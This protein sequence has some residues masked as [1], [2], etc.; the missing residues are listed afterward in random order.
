MRE[1]NRARN[2]RKQTNYKEVINQEYINFVSEAYNI[3][4]KAALAAFDALTE[5]P[6]MTV[7]CPIYNGEQHLYRNLYM[8]QKQTLKQIQIIYIDDYS[9]DNSRTILKELADLDKRITLIFNDHN[10]GIFASK[11]KA[12]GYIKANYTSLFDMDD[13]Y[14]RADALEKMYNDTLKYNSDYMDYYSLKGTNGKVQDIQNYYPIYLNY[15][16]NTYENQILGSHII[17]WLRV[18]SQKVAKKMIERLTEE[19]RQYFMIT[20]EDPS[21]LAVLKNV[22]NGARYIDE[23]MIYRNYHSE[24]SSAI[25]TKRFNN[26]K[27]RTFAIKVAV[28]NV[29][30]ALVTYKYSLDYREAKDMTFGEL[31]YILGRPYMDEIKIINEFNSRYKHYIFCLQF[32]NCKYVTGYLKRQINIFCNVV[33]N[34][35]L[36]HFEIIDYNN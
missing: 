27:Y 12:F 1:I 5:Q 30:C 9:S 18:I 31:W 21:L 6:K 34:Y 22:S 28:G 4:S 2:T 20:G 10:M 29:N 3:T 7:I 16:L 13:V 17:F 32:T 36:R 23:P 26:D 8:L 33:F 25:S 11:I 14:V 24:S 35:S 15:S 19:E